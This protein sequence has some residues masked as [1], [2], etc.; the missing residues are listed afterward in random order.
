MGVGYC[1]LLRVDGRGWSPMSVRVVSVASRCITLFPTPASTPSRQHQ[2]GADQHGFGSPALA[3][4]Q[5]TLLS[6]QHFYSTSRA[7]RLRLRFARSRSM[8]TH[9]L[10]YFTCGAPAASVRPLHFGNH[11]IRRR[12]FRSQKIACETHSSNPRRPPRGAIEYSCQ[13]EIKVAKC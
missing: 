7:A 10:F 11:S 3:R 13:H 12:Q 9:P 8:P 1:G 5:H 6:C 2:F 4:C